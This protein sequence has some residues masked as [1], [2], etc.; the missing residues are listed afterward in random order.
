MRTRRFASPPM[1]GKY[2][3]SGKMRLLRS[4]THTDLNREAMTNDTVH[5]KQV[6]IIDDN[7]DI[8]DY[9]SWVLEDSGYTVL[10]APHGAAALAVLAQADRVPA[11]ILLDLQMPILD[12]RG[13]RR[14]QQADPRWRS[15]PVILMSASGDPAAAAQDLQIATVLRKPFLPDALLA[16]IAAA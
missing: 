16:A 3:S 4:T 13:F 14:A 10:L 7:A 15:I 9:V 8:R 5:H 2:A 12:G 1:S 11:V 6:L